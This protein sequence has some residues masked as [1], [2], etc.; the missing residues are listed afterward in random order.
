ML[1]DGNDRFD[2]TLSS[3]NHIICI[4]C[5]KVVDIDTIINSNEIKNIERK[6]CFNITDSSFSLNGICY[7]CLNGKESIC[8]RK[9]SK[10]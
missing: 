1:E 7:D 2:R 6:T 5:K 9:P 4:V 10:K 8:R 3:H